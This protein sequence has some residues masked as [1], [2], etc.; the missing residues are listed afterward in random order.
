MPIYEYRCGACGFQRE[1]LQKMSDAPLVDCAECGKPTM[2]KMV[3]AAGFQLK[4]SGWYVTDF[5]SGAKPPAKADDKTA[6]KAD[7]Q[8]AAKSDD[9]SAEKSDGKPAVKSDDRPAAKSGDKPAASG[10]YLLVEIRSDSELPVVL[11][12]SFVAVARATRKIG[13]LLVPTSETPGT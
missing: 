13:A 4:G 10:S 2:S 6:S 8:P 1:I 12:V 5:K 9:R 11:P 7:D 3:T